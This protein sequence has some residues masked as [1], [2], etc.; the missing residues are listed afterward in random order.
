[1]DIDIGDIFKKIDKIKQIIYI[2]VLI[3]VIFLIIL[4]FIIISDFCYKYNYYYDIGKSSRLL[5]DKEYFEA[6]TE[7]FQIADKF[8][9]IRI[10]RNDEQNY[11]GITM[12]V[13]ILVTFYMCCIF[14]V[15]VWYTFSFIKDIKNFYYPTIII[16]LL[17]CSFIAFWVFIYIGLFVSD[18]NFD[19]S[20]FSHA[21]GAKAS[22]P[23]I[24]GLLFILR[25]V[26]YNDK[27]GTTNTF[28]GIL[29]YCFFMALLLTIIYILGSVVKIYKK[30]WEKGEGPDI[31]E[32]QVKGREDVIANFIK[33]ILGFEQVQQFADNQNYIAIKKVSGIF[34]T[35]LILLIIA[36]A[37]YVLI[38]KAK[39]LGISEDDQLFYKYAIL[40]PIIVLFVVYLIS[41]VV[42]EYNSAI[43]KY[44]LSDPII[45]YKNNIS[46]AA[47]KFDKIVN[48]EQKG[49]ITET[50]WY[51]CRNYGNAILNTMY[52]SVFNG[53]DTKQA[54]S[55]SNIDI[56][57]EYKYDESCDST[58]P[59]AFNDK[60]QYPEYNI[61]YYLNAK[62]RNKSIFYDFNKCTD[63]NVDVVK[64]VSD[65]LLRGVTYTK[66][67][68][69][70][71]DA[72]TTQ[73]NTLRTTLTSNI[74]AAMKNVKNRKVYNNSSNSLSYYIKT[75]TGT[76]LIT[77]FD[78]NNT[79]TYIE[80][81]YQEDA[82]IKKYETY[83]TNKIVSEYESMLRKFFK[84]YENVYEEN[85]AA[86][87]ATPNNDNIKSNMKSEVKG[88]A[89][90]A[91]LTK[92]IKTMFD[93]VNDAISISTYRNSQA[94]LS[95]Y[96]IMNYNNYNNNK[97][98]NRKVFDKC[99]LKKIIT[100]KRTQEEKNV[101]LFAQYLEEFSKEFMKVKEIYKKL[102]LSDIG[103][104]TT[105]KPSINTKLGEITTKVT[106][107]SNFINNINSNVN[108]SKDSYQYIVIP[109][110]KVDDGTVIDQQNKD[111]I[112]KSSYSILQNS[113]KST[114]N[115]FL[116]SGDMQAYYN[117]ISNPTTSLEVILSQKE[118]V[119]NKIA[120]IDS[121]LTYLQSD[122][123]AF[124]N[125]NKSI[126][127]A[128]IDCSASDPKKIAR[129]M[130]C[131]ANEANRIIYILIV[132]YVVAI[133]STNLIVI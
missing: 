30:G 8:D 119:K 91:G 108:A 124:L 122:V 65:N 12:S 62:K 23:L 133:L 78:T 14:A 63:I 41:S 68:A 70:E 13:T 50:P 40:F 34:G 61:D 72:T 43:N 24:I 16:L 123:R 20:I 44:I 56:T 115:M 42:T 76:Q 103:S 81:T 1:M 9:D 2:I 10:G 86:T 99:S 36:V 18:F 82:E 80:Q 25:I 45:Y 131:N 69:Y 87:P 49:I 120:I 27:L 11:T 33:N 46:K 100:D 66:T 74:L 90:V 73:I 29:I 4:H 35:V 39:V 53:I 129:D 110:F 51:I 107:D 104:Y 84:L 55:T 105:D 79:Y 37:G 21:L 98:Y 3:L 132:L 106:T 19:I 59:F 94:K 32:K 64:K 88:H 116:E 48:D 54:T 109:D 117:A 125:K 93:N 26:W 75:W 85:A 112:N 71:S 38:K 31:D 22:Y 17:F 5:C 111:T 126:S 97:V 47:S 113:I 127:P 58:K 130:I 67:L 52:A 89:Y 121:N 114:S 77:S 96:I 60:K 7:R 6:E 57:P 102:N 95:P 28:Y 83:I 15:M 128:I 118:K 101:E 92:I